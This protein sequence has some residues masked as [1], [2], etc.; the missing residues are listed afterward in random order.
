MEKVGFTLIA[1][2]CC[3]SSTVYATKDYTLKYDLTS[4]TLNVSLGSKLILQHS[5]SSSMFFVGNGQVNFREFRGNFFINNYVGDKIPATSFTVNSTANS[6]IISFKTEQSRVKVTL[7][8]KDS[9]PLVVSFVTGPFFNDFWLRVVAS[10]D[11]RVYGLGEQYSYLNLRGRTYPIW[12]REQGVGRNKSNIVTFFADNLA[13][14]AGGDYHTT[15]FPQTTFVSSRNLYCH[16]GGYNYAEVNLQPPNFHEIYVNGPVSSF[17]FQSKPDLKSLVGLLT[18]YLGTQP[19]LPDWVYTGAILGVQGGTEVMLQRYNQ[20]KQNG[21]PV[22]GLWIQDWAGV[23]KTSFGSRLFW[24]WIWNQTVYPDL[25]NEIKLLKGNGTRVLGY[26]NP[27]LNSN[28]DLYTQAAKGG[29]LIKKSDG[30]PYL[31]DF[32]EFNCGT[33]DL[34]NPNARKWY[35]EVIQTNMIDLGLSGW[36]ADFGEY[37]P[38]DGAVFYSN[39]TGREVHNQWPTLWAEVNR[40]AIDERNVTGDVVFWMRAGSAGTSKYTTLMWAG[41]QNVDFSYGDGLPSTIPAALNMGMSGI[42]I[43]HFDIGG[44]TTAAQFQKFGQALVRTEELLL[45][46]A[47]AA[48]F[49]PMFRSHEGNQPKANVQFY[50][51]DFIEKSFG[52]LAQIFVHISNYTKSVVRDN[53]DLGIPAQRPLF[54]EFPTDDISKSVSYQYMFGSDLLVAPV[55]QGNVETMNV[56]LPPGD[57]KFIWDK[58]EYSGHNYYNVTATMGMPPAFYKKTSEYASMFSEIQT[59]FPPLPLPPATTTSQPITTGSPCT[60]GSSSSLGGVSISLIVYMYLICVILC[61]SP[62][63]SFL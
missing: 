12:T 27:N 63:K 51:N 29:Y 46:S 24:N 26:I 52:R 59:K 49:T 22:S 61:F 30:T 57:W 11:E 48:I 54:M 2:L 5:P 47:E 53:H 7:E 43:T 58:N 1:L 16:Y 50:T 45:R 60:S 9:H 40:N 31:T 13:G 35:K 39:Q 38:A 37:V 10:P 23:L 25:D 56:Y 6:D 55:I 8:T 33:V 21:V 41:D 36:M 44:Y 42:G 62:L 32:G 18:H 14:G 17:Y 3:Y 19:K 34:T 15:Y 4:K 20:A 28:G